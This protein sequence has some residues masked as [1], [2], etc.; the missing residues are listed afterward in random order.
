MALPS[1]VRC[2]RIWYVFFGDKYDSVCLLQ[3]LYMPKSEHPG[4]MVLFPILFLTLNN[5]AKYPVLYLERMQSHKPERKL[6][7][8]N[9]F[10][11]FQNPFR[12]KHHNGNRAN[13][14]SVCWSSPK[15]LRLLM[16]TPLFH[17]PVGFSLPSQVDE[18]WQ[19]MNRDNIEKCKGPG[20]FWN[21]FWI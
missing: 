17:H 8:D 15:F 7:N 5:S 2:K 1:V 20:A 18:C 21:L 4:C 19:K 10:S 11:A 16:V 3:S 6:H 13:C 12:S 14:L 9:N